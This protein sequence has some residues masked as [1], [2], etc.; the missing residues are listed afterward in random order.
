MT[1]ANERRL[2]ADSD[3][4]QQIGCALEIW[5]S[6]DEPPSDQTVTTRPASKDATRQLFDE[7]RLH[8]RK[9]WAK[10]LP[11]DS[12]DTVVSERHKPAK[13]ESA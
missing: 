9:S 4:A 1:R 6:I 11:R 12:R 3:I 7:A 5:Q 13:P 2:S 10:S 8:E